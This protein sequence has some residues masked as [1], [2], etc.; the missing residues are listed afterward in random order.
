MDCNCK[1]L[2]KDFDT[3]LIYSILI[4]IIIMVSDPCSPNP[5]QNLGSCISDDQGNIQCSCQSGFTG[6]RCEIG[7]NISLSLYQW[8][9]YQFWFQ[10]LRRQWQKSQL[11]VGKSLILWDQRMIQHQSVLRWADPNPTCVLYRDQRTHYTKHDLMH[12]L[13]WDTIYS[14]FW[15]CPFRNLGKINFRLNDRYGH[16]CNQYV[17]QGEISKCERQTMFIR[18]VLSSVLHIVQ[19][20]T[21]YNHCLPP[22]SVGNSQL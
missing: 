21:A 7:K 10:L 18:G 11:W 16:F 17:I 6:E 2:R 8:R 4:L 20:D 15:S 12:P 13:L 9:R 3:G 22:A 14:V 1:N 19:L 5:C